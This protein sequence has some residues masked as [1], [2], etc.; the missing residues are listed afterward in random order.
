MEF[1]VGNTWLVRTEIELEDGSETEAR[2]IVGP[3]LYHSLYFRIWIGK[4]VFIL[5]SKEG[6]KKTAK[7]RRA[8][9]LIFGV[10]SYPG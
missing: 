2:G 6:L 4:T 8:F 5:S 7:T 9:K 3:I 10:V 1:G